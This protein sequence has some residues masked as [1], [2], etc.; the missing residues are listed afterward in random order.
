MS[1]SVLMSVY[2][3]EKPEYLKQCLSSLLNQK[4]R[5]EEVVLVEDGVIGSELTEVIDTFR[6]ALNIISVPL[7]RRSG[8]AKALNEGLQ[9]CPHD[10]VAR[11]DTD[12]VA[13]PER[14]EKQVAF[15]QMNP[16]VDVSSTSIEEYDINL[17]N[18]HFR[19]RLPLTHD[20]ICSFAKSRNPINH[21]S[22]IFRKRAVLKAGGY[23][24]VYPED[25]MLWIKMLQAGAR[26][27]N[28]PDYLLKARTGT[29]FLARRGREFLKG[30]LTI[31][32]YMYDSGFISG[33]EY[34]TSVLQRSILRMSPNF[35]KSFLYRHAR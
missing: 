20:E 7:R 32:R 8:F 10:L 14:F 6:E 35:I 11:M 18:L 1:F 15:M 25:Y 17:Q 30:E 4:L 28:H 12:D 34:L 16:E 5:A 33:I 27:A 19:K 29:D 3:G 9:H 31:F 22:C 23:P 26:F 24:E 2:D 21:M 13:L